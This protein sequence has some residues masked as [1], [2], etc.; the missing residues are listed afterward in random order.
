MKETGILFTPDNIRSIRGGRKTQTRRILKGSLEFKGPYNPKYLEMH[1]DAP[2]W[3][4]I[5]P[6]GEPGD[7]LYVKEGIV[8]HATIP[9]LVGYYL[10]GCRVTE[11]WEVRRTA[12]FMPKWAARMWLE[13]T[14]VRIERVQDISESDAMDEGVGTWFES[15]PHDEWD[16]DP[17][18]YRKGYRE[19]W[20]SI[21]AKK[22]PWKDNPWV[23]VLEFKRVDK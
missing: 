20:D 2:G 6:Y 10:D 11:E 21:S 3:K 5:C 17:D 22:H 19:L 8:R 14:D 7:R 12:M 23:W 1:K 16:G 15:H 9:Q 13:L 18:Q 4:K